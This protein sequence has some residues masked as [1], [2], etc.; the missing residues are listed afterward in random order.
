MVTDPEA[1]RPDPEED[2]GGPVKTFLEHLEDLR[3]VLI[4]SAVA[5]TIGMVVSLVACNWLVAVL[6]RPLERVDLMPRTG[7]PRLTLQLG[8]N[9]FGPF[10]VGTNQFGALSLGSNRDVVLQMV[11]VQVGTNHLLALQFNSHPAKPPKSKALVEL[12]NF[13]P[14]GGFLIAL[15][16]AL[17]GGI[18]LASP[19]IIYFIGDFTLPALR[20][21][22]K[23]YILRGFAV[24]T[25][26]FLSGV[27]FCYFILMEL[28]LRA[29]VMYSAWLGFAADQWRAE[30]YISFVCKF[31]LGMGIGFELPVVILVLVKIGILDYAKLVAFRRYMIV[32]CLVLGAV[33]TTPEVVTQVLM[34]APL[35]LLYEICV[36]ITWYWERQEKKRVAKEEV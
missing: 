36:W 22:E 28:A 24:G 29:S 18:I 9:Q 3:W 16:V 10:E 26:L 35:Y 25:G 27:A 34:A 6:K 21:R 17:Y 33:L 11:P 2:E 23:K 5:V 4:K 31:M 12:R 19:F 1:E 8:T 20:I 14:V 15:H 32:V 30:E 13:G 7:N